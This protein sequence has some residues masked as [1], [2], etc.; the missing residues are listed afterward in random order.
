MSLTFFALFYD[1]FLGVWIKISSRCMKVFKGQ[2]ETNIYR[3]SSYNC[4]GNYSFL[5][6]GVRQVFK[7][8]NYC[9]LTFWKYI[10][11]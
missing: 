2:E 9:F 4:R 5:E 3:I 7:G 8:G 11:K 10:P 6:V 1:D